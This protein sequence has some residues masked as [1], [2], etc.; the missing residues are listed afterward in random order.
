[1]GGG[2][3]WVEMGLCGRGGGRRLYHRER[4]RDHR[5]KRKERETVRGCLFFCFYFFPVF[6]LSKGC[7]G[8]SLS[9]HPIFKRK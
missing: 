6:F 9:L 4:E 1:M 8:L 2:D 5:Q 3:G 7:F